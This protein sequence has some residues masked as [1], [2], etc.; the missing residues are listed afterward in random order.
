[1]FPKGNGFHM[2]IQFAL[3]KEGRKFGCLSIK[4]RGFADFG[5]FERRH[6]GCGRGRSWGRRGRI[7]SSGFLFE[8][9]KA[10]AK[11]VILI[12][13]GGECFSFCHN[14][15]ERKAGWTGRRDRCVGFSHH[16]P[17]WV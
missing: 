6:D 10:F 2:D 5:F 15:M 11:E 17:A 14:V 4:G 13:K 3:L 9:S 16:T 1:M 7:L 8:G 12:I